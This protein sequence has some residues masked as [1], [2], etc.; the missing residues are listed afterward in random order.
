MTHDGVV[1]L[2]RLDE[3]MS[4]LHTVSFN[5]TMLRTGYRQA[6]RHLIEVAQAIDPSRL[7]ENALDRW[8]LRDL[9]G[10]ASRAFLTVPAY[11]QTGRD[12]P[13]ELDH[14]FDYVAAYTSSHGDPNAI[15]ERARKSGED[16][17]DDLV[18]GLQRSFDDAMKS[19]DDR[20]DDAP[21]KSPAGVMKLIDYLPN[22]VFELVIHT[23]DIK[24]SQ[25][26]EASPDA[27]PVMVAL[28]FCAA[29]AAETGQYREVLFGLTGRAD[30]ERFSVLG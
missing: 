3:A 22:R 9:I 11:L 20:P 2:G 7:D 29:L 6:G 12:L 4:N 26:I 28:T 5:P 23:E 13:V 21:L 19:L 24:V 15:A 8:S 18:A 27:T 10:H 30:L 16:L 1:A 17:G 14:A 25:G